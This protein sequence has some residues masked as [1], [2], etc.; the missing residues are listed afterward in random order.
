MRC[1]RANEGVGVGE[2]KVFSDEGQ[3][4]FALPGNGRGRGVG[5][6]VIQE[7]WGLNE[8][9]RDF[10]DRLAADGFVVLAPDLYQ[11]VVVSEPDEAGKMMMSLNLARAAA[12]MT[13]AVNFLAHHPSV[14]GD[15]VGVIGFC[16]GGGLALWLASLCPDTVSACVP[17][18]GVI[19][20]P[21]AQPDWSA[22]RAR[23]QG[24]YAELDESASPE[25]VAKLFAELHAAGVDAEY[26]IY[27]G[28]GHAF[29]ND[30]R[31]EVYSAEHTETALA[32]AEAFLR[33][34]AGVD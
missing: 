33:T 14:I 34:S 11:G 23:V 28:A 4:Y 20:W 15:G 13:G 9:I 10:C 3:G 29:A 30:R 17:F 27:P 32:R 8:Q 21:G 5:V 26:F 24:H 25:H 6:I 16:M 1:T 12:D 22:M 31:P 7:W 2:L 18:Y 19:P